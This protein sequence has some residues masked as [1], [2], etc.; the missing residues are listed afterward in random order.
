MAQ[1]GLPTQAITEDFGGMAQ[2]GAAMLN[3][4]KLQQEAKADRD[5]QKKLDFEDRYGLDESLLQMGDTEFRTVNDVTTEA[6]STFRDRYYD[7]YKQLEQD[8]TNLELKKR[9]SK[10]K[11]SVTNMKQSHEKIRAIGE[12]YLAKI[13]AGEISGVDEE[14]WKAILEATDKGRV[15]V[16][17]DDSDNMQLL[18]YDKDGKLDRVMNH[19]ELINGSLIKA[20]DTDTEVNELVKGLGGFT[21]DSKEG[22]YIRTQNL[23]GAKQKQTVDK[24]VEGKLQDKDNF[25]DLLYQATGEKKKEGFTDSDKAIVKS[26]VNDQVKGRYDESDTVKADGA[27]IAAQ[28]NA[29]NQANKQEYSVDKLN[30]AVDDQEGALMRDNK[31]ILSYAGGVQ[32]DPTGQGAIYDEVRVNRNGQIELWGQKKIKRKDI[33]AG[34]AEGDAELAAAQKRA[35][36]STQY[37]VEP[38]GSGNN[39]YTFYENVSDSTKDERDISKYANLMQVGDIKGLQ[40]VIDKKM[41]KRWGAEHVADF[42]AGKIKN[43]PATN[44][45]KGGTV[46]ND[47][48]KMDESS[49]NA[50]DPTQLE[51]SEAAQYYRALN[52]R[53]K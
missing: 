36:A 47:Y 11:S 16:N 52:A 5:Y 33:Q 23:Y 3:Q 40:D 28:R 43:D 8:P 26:F 14:E 49:F 44:G 22:M 35:E 51:L 50:I 7:V 20:F 2:Q 53:N 25:A 29:I 6:V 31:M 46:T 12:D 30:V 21:S 10:I 1:L 48:L 4:Q 18:F 45:G 17:M 42:Y 38:S 37:I 39:T 41:T 34:T 13:E 19:K 32:L 15:K 24:W 27:K 9:L